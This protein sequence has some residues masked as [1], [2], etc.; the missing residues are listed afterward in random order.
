M[1]IQQKN[2]IL[3]PRG[4]SPKDRESIGKDIINYI[5]NRTVKNSL[6]KN[7]DKFAKYSKEYAQQEHKR[8]VNLTQSGDM[9]DNLKLLNHRSGSIT[10]GYESD[11]DG[12][13][14]V[15]GNRLGTYG[16]KKPIAGKARDFLGLLPEDLQY[17]LNKYSPNDFD[18][19][20][21]LNLEEQARTLTQAQIDF[22]ERDSFLR[23]LGIS[24]TGV[25]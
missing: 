8:K 5:K 20:Q 12:M 15:E 24:N 25:I 14:K 19:E 16:Q 2:R 10:I 17:I 7:D 22:L 9:L 11:Y 18:A 1:A 23:S 21:E 13:G 4:L 3:I 6:D